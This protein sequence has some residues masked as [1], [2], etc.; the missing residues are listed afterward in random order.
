MECKKTKVINL[1][2]GPGTGKSVIASSLFVKMKKMGL[3]T[4]L[5]QEYA[6]ELAYKEDYASLS[7]Q[8]YVTSM[9]FY[10]QF[11]VCDK[12]DYIVTDSSILTG[13][14]YNNVVPDEIFVPYVRFLF[15][16]FNNINI[17][18]KRNPS[19]PYEAYGRVE[20]QEEAINKDNEI[21]KM[22]EKLGVEFKPVE[23]GYNTEEEILKFI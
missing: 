15:E 14:C 17:F 12:V 21:I 19:I 2:G 23:I 8:P 6:K 18:L 11:L 13:L 16:R 9:Q 3:K 5:V 10:K 22:L 20:T 4:E 7:C 1:F